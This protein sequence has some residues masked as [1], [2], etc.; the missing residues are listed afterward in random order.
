MKREDLCNKIEEAIPAFAFLGDYLSCR[1]YGSGHINDTFLIRFRKPDGTVQPY[2]LQRIN[3]DIFCPEELMENV[4]LVTSFLRQKI[5]SLGGDPERETLCILPT[6]QGAPF[7]RDS[8][9][10]YWRGYRFIE[11]A[12]TYDQ[13]E[14]PEQ[15]Y[16]SAV[17]FGRFQFLLADFPAEKLHE[18]IPFF[19]H[20]RSRFEALQHAVEEDRLDRAKL[21]KREIAFAYERETETRI[22]VD[23]LE[24]GRLPLRVTHN[25]TKL[26]NVM[27]DDRTGQAVCVIDLDTVMPGSALYDFGDSI[28]FGAS[29]GAE[30]EPDLDK[31]R[32]DQNLFR[33]YTK[34]YWK[35]CQGVLTPLEVE[36]LPTGAKLMTLECGIRFLTDFLQGDTYFKIHREGHNLDRCRTQFHL[37]AGMEAQWDAMRTIVEESCTAV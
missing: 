16:Q 22:L 18:V 7:Y 15:F 29:T 1:P 8:I 2:I 5:L 30:D 35:G 21:V 14:R 32:F 31:V 24:S 6:K 33:Q 25:D 27:L 12:R 4:L 28:R 19:H 36:L 20:T 11:D 17:A 34:G 9:G 13:V 10:C 26:N 37:V 3:H 23:L